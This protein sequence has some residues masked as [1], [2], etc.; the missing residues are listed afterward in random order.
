MSNPNQGAQFSCQDCGKSFFTTSGYEPHSHGEP[1][2]IDYRELEDISNQ[3]KTHHALS[4]VE[5]TR[6]VDLS[7]HADLLDH[8]S[9]M[10]GHA[11]GKY[12]KWRNAYDEL[13]DHIDGVRSS[14]G[15]DFELTHPELRIMHEKLHEHWGQEHLTNGDEHYHL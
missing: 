8:L 5:R 14:Y 1:I 7:N 6:K 13:P 2:E 9:S 15:D 12:A 11:V 10:N 3:A 4:E